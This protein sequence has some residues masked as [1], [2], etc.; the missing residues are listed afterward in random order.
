MR[1]EVPPLRLAAEAPVGM[2]ELCAARDI[3][4]PH[5]EERA[6]RASR[7][8]ASDVVLVAHPSRRH[9]APP[10]GEVGGGP[11]RITGAHMA[12]EGSTHR[13]LTQEEIA[14]IVDGDRVFEGVLFSSAAALDR[15]DLSEAVFTEC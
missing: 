13:L 11:G 3:H 2:A 6:Q 15:V 9:F 5:P 1:Q 7:R 10:Q 8:V 14:A 4:S 12:A